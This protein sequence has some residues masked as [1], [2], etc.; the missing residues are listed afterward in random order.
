MSK[1]QTGYNGLSAIAIQ[2]NNQFGS[3]DMV[4]LY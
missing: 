4:V 1:T 3:E 2:E